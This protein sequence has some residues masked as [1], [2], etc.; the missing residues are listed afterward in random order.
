MKKIITGIIILVTFCLSTNVLGDETMYY[1]NSDIVAYIDDMPIKSYNIYGYTGIVAENLADYNFSVNYYEQY[2]LLTIDYIYDAPCKAEPSYIPS[3]AKK[4]T[5]N[6]AGRI[7]KSDISVRVGTKYIQGYNIGG[8][9]IILIDDLKFFGKVVW[10]PDERK[11]CYNNQKP[12]QM[13]AEKKNTVTKNENIDFF[14]C[15]LTQDKDGNLYADGEN[16]SYLDDIYLS[17]S[18]SDGLKF[19]FSVFQ[20]VINETAGLREKLDSVT[21][22]D[23]NGDV[24]NDTCKN[25]RIKICINDDFVKVNKIVNRIGN[26]HTDYVLYLDCDIEKPEQI[27]KVYIELR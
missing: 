23:Y 19:G 3:P 11:I 21:N 9:T 26:G 4:N 7:Y 12:W 22:I 14:T 25:D 5:G 16:V 13:T 20:R 24:V 6:I 15:G 27:K 18:P 8:K 2:R 10:F 17:N 1:R